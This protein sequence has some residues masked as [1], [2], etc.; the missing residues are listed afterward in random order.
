MKK[1]RG[2]DKRRKG[3]REYTAG[4]ISGQIQ[5]GQSRRGAGDWLWCSSVRGLP[6]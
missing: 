4:D 3:G 1:E 2:R 5:V 6:D